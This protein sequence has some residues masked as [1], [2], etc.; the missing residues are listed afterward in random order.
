MFASRESMLWFGIARHGLVRRR[1]AA[2]VEQERAAGAL[3]RRDAGGEVVGRRRRIGGWGAEY[4]AW[5]KAVV[6]L[7]K[8]E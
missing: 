1:E 8:R 5:W 7:T 6:L 2:R 4:R 3:V